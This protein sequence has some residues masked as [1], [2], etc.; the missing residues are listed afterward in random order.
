MLFNEWLL[1]FKFNCTNLSQSN[2][3][4]ELLAKKKKKSLK[5]MV[6]IERKGIK[7]DETQIQASLV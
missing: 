7:R 3:Q 6:C 4:I 1:L 2:Q 5:P